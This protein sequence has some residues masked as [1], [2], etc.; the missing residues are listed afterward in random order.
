MGDA[1]GNCPISSE[2]TDYT[3]ANANPIRYRGY[4]YDSDTGLYYCNARYYSPKWR[5][6]IS[7]VRGIVSADAVNGL[8]AYVYANNNPVASCVE[9]PVNIAKYTATNN[10]SPKVAKPDAQKSAAHDPL[11]FSVGVVTPE[12]G[13]MPSWMDVYGF[14]IKGSLGWGYT[15]G[16]GYSLASFSIGILD[17]TF[18]TPKW[19]ASLPAN[20][21]ANPNIYLGVGA[22]NANASIGVGLSG[23][24]EIITGTIGVQFGDAVSFG[25]KGYVGIG[26]TLDFTNGIRFGAGFGLGFELY[27]AIDWYELFN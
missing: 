3:V 2:T 13:N 15:F 8:N 6:F 7:P 22:W 20:H 25:A 19:F 4:Y 10:T 26:F 27:L 21:L 12:S 14:Y 16:E 23:T 1:W 17:A 5:R 18:H 24:A 9:V 11:S